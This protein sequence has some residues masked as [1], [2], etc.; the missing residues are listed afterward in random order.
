MKMSLGH[1]V[2]W[3]VANWSSIIA[4][5]LALTGAASYFIKALEGLIKLLV[6]AF[7]G[8]QGADGE[9]LK[10]AAWIDSLKSSAWLNTIAASPKVDK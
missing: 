10:L 3:V 4:A 1:I 8:L 7:P 9:L 6:L 2:S 5:L